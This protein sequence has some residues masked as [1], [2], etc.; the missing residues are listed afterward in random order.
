MKNCMLH[1]ARSASIFRPPPPLTTRPSPLSVFTSAAR[2]E[3]RVG[4]LGVLLRPPHD[5]RLYHLWRRLRV[6]VRL[7]AE[8][9][10]SARVAPCG[11][12][13]SPHFVTALSLLSSLRRPKGSAQDV[14]R[15]EA[16]RRLTAGDEEEE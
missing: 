8:R 13:H 6:Q 14:A 9:E 10:Y 12:A 1:E 2:R 3:A 4:G 7:S 16:L 11:L 5:L 15:E